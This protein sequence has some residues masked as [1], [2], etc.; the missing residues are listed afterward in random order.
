MT[1]RVFNAVADYAMKR[2]V[3]IDV[4]GGGLMGK[5]V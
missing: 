1:P 2:G 5:A 4:L 3:Q